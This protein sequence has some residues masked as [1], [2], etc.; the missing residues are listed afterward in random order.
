MIA[1]RRAVLPHRM[2]NKIVA[3]AAARG[4][5]PRV[6]FDIPASP[7][8]PPET[9][10]VKSSMRYGPRVLAS[11]AAGAWVILWLLSGHVPV[12]SAGPGLIRPRPATAKHYP[13]PK[14]LVESGAYTD[15]RIQ[16]FAARAHDETDFEWPAKS[17]S[18]PLVLVFIK[19][20]CPCNVE[21]EPLFR[22]LEEQ[23]R[24]VA[25][26]AGV[27]DADID[28]AR[29]YV[30]ANHLAHP[31]LADP[32]RAI[33]ERFQARNG[34]YVALLRPEGKVDTLWPG[35]SAEMLSELARRIAALAEITVRPV[36]VT[37]APRVLTTGCPFSS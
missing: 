33:I 5:S 14:Q 20:D 6:G 34:A 25:D 3:S 8:R 2:R 21:L 29:S 16:P 12:E 17:G 19:R 4:Y 36:D 35:Y 15:R 11:C 37:G 31:V 32:E 1:S 23:Y 10:R 27:I 24:D 26:F 18:R 28:T 22:R 13:T 30:T 9:D 7:E